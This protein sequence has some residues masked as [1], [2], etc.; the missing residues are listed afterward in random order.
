[1]KSKKHTAL[2]IGAIFSGISLLLTLTFFVPM[3]CIL[4]AYFL[5]VFVTDVFSLSNKT[6]GKVTTLILGILFLSALYIAMRI[7]KIRAEKGEEMTKKEIIVIMLIIFAIV[8]PLGYYLLLWATNFPIDAL[9]AMMS[10]FSFPVTSLSFVVIGFL[11]DWYWKK[12]AIT[13]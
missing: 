4:P 2:K 12:N 5:D 7:V 1:M 3:Y 8:H 11:M 13:L 6:G 10:I 9:V